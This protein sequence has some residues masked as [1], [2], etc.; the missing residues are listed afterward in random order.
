MCVQKSTFCIN[1]PCVNIYFF[2]SHPCWVA[3]FIFR[4][5]TTLTSTTFY[6]RETVRQY[7]RSVDKFIRFFCP[8]L[9]FNELLL[10]EQPIVNLMKSH[11]RQIPFRRIG[12]HRSSTHVAS[13]SN[14]NSVGL[15]N[16]NMR[17][18]R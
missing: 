7:Q 6:L 17:I 10:K 18:L 11:I 9:A 2:P 16:E 8:G 4:P 1:R 3:A 12:M 5:K 13:P 14:L 15:S